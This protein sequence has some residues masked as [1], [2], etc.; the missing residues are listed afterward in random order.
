MAVLCIQLDYVVVS[1]Q[2]DVSSLYT[3][4]P[5]E[6]GKQSILYYPQTNPDT[7]TT[8][9]PLPEVLAELAEIIL[10][11]LVCGPLEKKNYILCNERLLKVRVPDCISRVPK[12]LEE[13]AYWKG[14]NGLND[15]V[16]QSLLIIVYL[17]CT[18]TITIQ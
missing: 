13:I 11:C 16:M 2:L 10:F 1:G 5:H 15:A 18:C 8:E 17:H 14:N 6:D 9:Q 7:Y 12:S 4:I 3:N